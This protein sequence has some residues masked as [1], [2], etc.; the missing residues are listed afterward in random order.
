MVKLTK[1]LNQLKKE[2][3]KLKAEN[4]KLAKELSV[5]NSADST[6]S[7][8]GRRVAIVALIVFSAILLVL[9]NLLF[10]AGNTVTNTDKYVATITPLVEDPAI[11]KAIASY[12]T[13]QIFNNVDVEPILAESLPPKA[14]FLAPTLTTQLQNYTGNV[15]QKVVASDKFQQV[16]IDTNRN[17][18][19]RLIRATA[20]SEGDGTISVTKA[21]QFLST[22]LANTNLSF[23][24]GKQLP[25][26][27]GDIAI[28][29][30]EYL[31]AFRTLVNNIDTW[32]LLTIGLFVITSAGAVFISRK[33]RQ[34]AV[35]LGLLFVAAMFATLIALRI[36]RETVSAGVDSQY[37]LAVSNAYQ[38]IVNQLV[39]SS[40]V[41]MV[42]GILI[43]VIAWITG[44]TRSAQAVSSRISTLLSG[45]VH[46]ALFGKKENSLTVWVGNHKSLLQWGS[47][48]VFGLIMLFT[49]LTATKLIVFV[50][51]I[52]ISYVVFEFLAAPSSK[53]K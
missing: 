50:I 5:A 18:H 10:W 38:I 31:P 45:N 17:T 11:Q 25:S 42:T 48:V 27:V 36:G 19:E 30:V 39:V 16:W 2:N 34:T 47:V 37:Q 43:A 29:K 1:S 41:I 15:V 28:V 32:R 22:E 6:R 20:N 12:A 26:R 35:T 14:S 49:T 51:L 21:Y 24:A 52:L 9:G 40:Y 8:F 13:V 3:Q 33:R 46:Q 23:L 53:R 4:Q 44:S 7:G